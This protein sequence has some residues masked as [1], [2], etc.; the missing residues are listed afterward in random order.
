MKV[1]LHSFGKL[2]V[3]FTVVILLCAMGVATLPLTSS[4]A[5]IT[6]RAY[7]FSGNDGAIPFAGVIFDNDGNLYGAH[8]WR[9][10]F[11]VQQP[12]RNWLRRCV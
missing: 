1:T 11:D 3:F 5:A 6:E 8:L 10:Q 4:S 9:Q 7:S 2:A 12:G